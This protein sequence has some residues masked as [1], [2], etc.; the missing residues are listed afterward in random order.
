MLYSVQLAASAQWLA[1]QQLLPTDPG[2]PFGRPVLD[3]TAL[4]PFNAYK[5]TRCSGAPTVQCNNVMLSHTQG[6]T[7]D[8]HDVLSG[9]RQIDVPCINRA[10]NTA[11]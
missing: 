8:H 9:A 2:K 7:P 6:Q 11:C 1:S 10:Y 4:K 3:R 5:R